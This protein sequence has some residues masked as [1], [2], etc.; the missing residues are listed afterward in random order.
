M[1]EKPVG[2]LLPVILFVVA[3]VATTLA[4]G[5]AGGQASGAAAAQAGDDDYDESVLLSRIRQ[6]TYEGRRAGEGY[7]SPDGMRLT[8][9]SEREPGNPFYQIYDLDLTMGDARRISPGMGK[10]T[11]SFFVP[12]TGDIMFSSTHADPRSDELQREELDMRARGEERRYAWDYDPAMDIYLAP[13]EAVAAAGPDGAVDPAALIRL[14]DTRGY[15]AE[16]SVSPGGEWIVFS[17][18][19]HAYDRELSPE[20]ARLL[21]FDPSYFADLYIM[22]IDGSEVR[23]LTDAPGNDG[24]PFFFPDGSRI[25]WRRFSE[26]GLLGDVYS[27]RPDGT[28]ERRLTDFTALSWA[29]YVHPSGDYILFTSNKL[30]FTNFEIY[31]VDVEGTKEPVQVTTT[32]G[33]DGLPVPSPDGNQVAF[34]SSRHGDGAR[35]SGQI[36]LADWNHEKALELLEAAPRR[37]R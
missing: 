28:D 1:N 26:D 29:P 22:R 18:N 3:M 11:C 17:S 27:I 31:M 37:Q 36:F 34:T 25:I 16:G 30:G 21:E 32:D 15:D 2:R 9:Q 24:G 19:R 6:L 7:Y 5:A 23:R 10:T 14:T 20:D 13:G 4:S 35:G 8:L 12:G 33:F